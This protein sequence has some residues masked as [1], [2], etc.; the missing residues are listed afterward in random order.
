VDNTKFRLAEVPPTD[1]IGG[2][3]DITFV[4]GCDKTIETCRARFSQEENFSGIGYGMQPYNPN[5]ES[6]Q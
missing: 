3:A 5:W 4:A 6:P 2:S 1:W